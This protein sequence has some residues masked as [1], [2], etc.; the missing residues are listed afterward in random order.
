MSV[1]REMAALSTSL[2]SKLN[3]TKIQD[4]LQE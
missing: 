4:K 1:N 2:S 3:H